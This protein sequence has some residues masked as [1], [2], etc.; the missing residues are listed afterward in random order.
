MAIQQVGGAKV[1]VITGSKR[2]P[3]LTSTGQSWANLVSQQKYR[4]WQEAQREALMN[5]KFDE[6]ERQQQLQIQENLAWSR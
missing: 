4:L 3:R 6:M 2:D 1:Y 5:I